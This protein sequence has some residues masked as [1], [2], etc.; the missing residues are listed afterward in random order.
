MMELG[1]QYEMYQLKEGGLIYLDKQGYYRFTEK[2]AK[3]WGAYPNQLFHR[4]WFQKNI[5]RKLE[6]GEFIHHINGI[7]TDNRFEN[8]MLVN[9]K[10]HKALHTL[11]ANLERK[12]CQSCTKIWLQ[13][14]N[15]R[16]C[17]IQQMIDEDEEDE[18]WD[19]DEDDY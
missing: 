11:E 9:K 6:F 19:Y 1:S 12:Y 2:Y 15:C 3:D 17:Y 4:W 7:K 14:D 10:D 5:Q 8:L 18:E 13:E 16:D